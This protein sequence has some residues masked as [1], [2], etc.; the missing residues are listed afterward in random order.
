MLHVRLTGEACY[1]CKEKGKMACEKGGAPHGASE[2]PFLECKEKKS[3]K[4][5]TA[6]NQPATRRASPTRDRAR[7]Q[8]PDAT[9]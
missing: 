1:Q 8:T 3:Q 2:G 5:M 7:T 6:A 4:K 9:R